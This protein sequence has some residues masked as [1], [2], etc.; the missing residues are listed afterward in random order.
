MK[1]FLKFEH[2]GLSHLK[3]VLTEF[4]RLLAIFTDQYNFFLIFGETN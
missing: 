1:F 3:N 4:Y 2:I